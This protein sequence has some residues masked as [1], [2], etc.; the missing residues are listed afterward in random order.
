MTK[1]R[2]V[3]NEAKNLKTPK[4]KELFKSKILPENSLA[5]LSILKDILKFWG[6]K[7]R[8]SITVHPF[9]KASQLL[10]QFLCKWALSCQ[11]VASGTERQQL[12]VYLAEKYKN[13]MSASIK[14]Q[15]V[16]QGSIILFLLLWWNNHIQSFVLC[17]EA[18]VRLCH[19]RV[20][21]PGVRRLTVRWFH[22]GI[23]LMDCGCCRII[24]TWREAERKHLSSSTSSIH[25]R[26]RKT[27]SSLQI[28]LSVMFDFTDSLPETFIG[29]TYYGGKGMSAVA[30][31]R[32]MTALQLHHWIACSWQFGSPKVW[33][34]CHILHCTLCCTSVLSTAC[35]LPQPGVLWSDF[36]F[37]IF[38]WHF[39]QWK[40]LHFSDRWMQD[41][42]WEQSEKL[43]CTLYIYKTVPAFLKHAMHA[44]EAERHHQKQFQPQLPSSFPSL[45]IYL[46]YGM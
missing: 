11:L 35:K 22:Q 23:L 15:V 45:F 18:C 5:A 29:Y 3:A 2:S 39:I 34:E 6:Q 17:E 12:D 25:Q 20:N 8:C 32:A 9:Q 43:C 13:R 46:N 41:I 26:T 31:V 19:L 7:I 24:K 44:G 38:K 4:P 42:F 27:E 1:I 10:A 36:N 28:P 33:E 30:A 37:S 14:F 21:C 16:K 40:H